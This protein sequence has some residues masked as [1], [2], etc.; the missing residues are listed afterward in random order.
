[1]CGLRGGERR[2][3]SREGSA[4]LRHTGVACGG[5]DAGTE[6]RDTRERRGAWEERS[7]RIR[8]R[9]ECAQQCVREREAG[10]TGRVMYIQSNHAQALV[11][12]PSPAGST[13]KATR[14][15]SFETRDEI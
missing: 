9:V 3:A 14:A 7:M 13:R 15:R 8:A 11:P 4:G 2:D 5:P 12:T 1:M 6:S 10:S